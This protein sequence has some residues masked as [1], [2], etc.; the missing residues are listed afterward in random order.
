MFSAN[1]LGA[2][3]TYQGVPQ[4]GKFR[5]RLEKAHQRLLR[6]QKTHHPMRIKTMLIHGAVYPAAFFGAEILPVGD[7]HC[8]KLRTAINVALYGDSP[9]Q[10]PAI[11][12]AATPGLL[13]PMLELVVRVLCAIQRML[14]K[15][16]PDH[17]LTFYKMV[18]KHSG[19]PYQ[20]RGLAGVLAYY[21]SKFDWQLGPSGCLSHAAFCKIPLLHL[22]KA[23][24]TRW[25]QHA[26]NQ[27]LLLLHTVRKRCAKNACN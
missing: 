26:W 24:L 13:D 22:S 11:A 20:C 18:S 16:P 4:L 12:V 2:Q 9:T 1:D 19:L 5:D 8:R 7:T 21:L 23:Q 27:D 3:H 17:Q 10:N 25:A 15:L 6:L 14:R